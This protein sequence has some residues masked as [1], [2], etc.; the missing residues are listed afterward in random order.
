MVTEA[1]NVLGTKLE[2]C[3]TS[4]MTGYYRDG[5]CNTGGGD[6]GVH[7]VCAKVTEEFLKY[8]KRMGNDLSTPVPDFKFP[9]LKPGDCWCLCAS[10]W[11]EAMDAGCAPLVVLS[12]TH[13]LTLEYVSLQELKEHA[14]DL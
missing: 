5:K 8:T 11:K 2:T 13:V 9:G 6:L 4:P 14:A 3:C 12:A 7:T 1:T 10:R